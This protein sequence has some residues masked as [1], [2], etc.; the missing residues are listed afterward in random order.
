M[1]NNEIVVK[2]IVDS[3]TGE[4]KLKGFAKTAE[5]SIGRVE[6]K[7]K[8][9]RAGFTKLSDFG[10]KF[11]FGL[12]GLRMLTRPLGDLIRL[13]NEQEKADQ[14][15]AVAMKQVGAYSDANFKAMKKQASAIQAVTTTGDEQVQMLQSLALNMG[16]SFEKTDEATRGAIG[17]AQSFEKAGLNQATAMKG[18]AL[19]Y[20]G[21]FTQ[22]QRYIPALRSAGTNTEKMAILQKMMSNGFKQSEA[23][24]KTSAGQMEQFKNIVGDMKEKL[25]DLIKKA[26]L[27]L[28]AVFKPVL[29]WLNDLSP[30]TINFSGVLLVLTGVA[31]KVVPVIQAISAET[32]LLGI[33]IKSA[34]G[35]IGLIITAATLLYTAWST[36]LGGFQEAL[37]DAWSYLKEWTSSG[38][39][40][41]KGYIES[42]ITGFGILGRVIKKVFQG[43]LTGAVNEI[44]G[45][46]AKIAG[47]VGGHV[48]AITAIHQKAEQERAAISAQFAAKE[49]KAV[50]KKVKAVVKSEKALTAA[51]F[52][53]QKARYQGAKY[54]LANIV[55]AVKASNEKRLQAAIKYGQDLKA[56]NDSLQ[57]YLFESGRTSVGW[58]K[59]VLDDRLQAAKEKYGAESEEYLKLIDKKKEIDQSYRESEAQNQ[60]DFTNSLRNVAQG[61]FSYQQQLRDQKAKRDLAA[62]KQTLDNQKSILAN[63]LKNGKI[64]KD[65]YNK[66][67]KALDAEDARRTKQIEAD[68]RKRSKIEA[69]AAGA[70]ILATAFSAAMDAYK[71]AVKYLPPFVGEAVGAVLAGT[72]MAFGVAQASRAQATGFAVGGV[73]DKPTSAIIGEAGP[74]I[75]APKKS[76]IDVVQNL[77]SGGD[78]RPRGAD[79]AGV[80]DPGTIAKAVRES[81]DGASWG[82][83]VDSDGLA[84][85][86]QT[87]NGNLS[88]LEF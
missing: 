46:S 86:L 76:F 54:Y 32:T 7:L 63:E 55:H 77:I 48:D 67:I 45:A 31:W 74:E 11:F 70:Q 75:I 19:A 24:A 4:V 68:R 84:I 58:Y 42:I 13:S 71:A 59:Q 15:L 56:K 20:Q 69:L 50:K 29:S 38:W 78:I 34:L 61:L 80:V 65:E 23:L 41:V 22:L 18:I 43:D 2:L 9:F 6:K 73:V 12:Q 72:T 83:K 51:I 57:D 16:I 85:A 39:E 36:N 17:L 8:G 26:L 28:V 62:W 53:E 87:G 60:A 37:R 82:V 47:V 1:P 25:G 79:G 66:R 5:E 44:A 52:S 88:D 33:S 14:N 40:I 21:N 3:K 10:T 35:W 81:L 27:P 64:S 30:A 49:E